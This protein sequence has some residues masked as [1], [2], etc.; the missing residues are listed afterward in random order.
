MRS[1]EIRTMQAKEEKV[2]KILCLRIKT[3]K[4]IEFRRS[5]R[6]IWEDF[7]TKHCVCF[8]TCISMN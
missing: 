7:I 3:L 2:N 1:D 6:E 5:I 8:R 4:A